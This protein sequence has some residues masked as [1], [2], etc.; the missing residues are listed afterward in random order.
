MKPTID[1]R[2]E[3]ILRSIYDIDWHLGESTKLSIKSLI[4]EVVG[5]VL[6]DPDLILPKEDIPFREDY[7]SIAKAVRKLKSLLI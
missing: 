2:I 6:S 4:K 1:E 3:R 7:I 5:E